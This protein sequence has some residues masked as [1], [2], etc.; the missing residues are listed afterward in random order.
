MAEKVF[1]VGGFS[2]TNEDAAKEAMNELNG[3]N[4]MKN[5]I[6]MNNINSVLSSYNMMNDKGLFKTPVG[7][8]FL[9]SLRTKL[10]ESGIEE[11]EIKPVKTNVVTALS[12][13]K[14]KIK[15]EKKIDSIYRHRFIDM[16]IVNVILI[17]VLILFAIIANNSNN[18]NVINYK[19]RIDE[20]YKDIDNS[21]S[22][23]SRE[24]TNKENQLREKAEELGISFD[25]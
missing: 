10:I 4:Y 13:K 20:Q 9:N 14:G 1:E 2:F 18:L 11:S 21:L 5:R 6:D 3:V 25:D 17:V 12:E 24:L 19:D 7:Y 15:K 8:S 16:I 23:W 22:E